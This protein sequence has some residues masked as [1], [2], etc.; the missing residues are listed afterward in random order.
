MRRS[1]LSPNSEK[2]VQSALRARAWSSS[3]LNSCINDALAEPVAASF[4]QL[5]QSSQREPCCSPIAARRLPLEDCIVRL[6][7]QHS[8]IVKLRKFEPP[9]II[10]VKTK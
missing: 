7:T 9:R 3:Y 1:N 2:L 4:H 6:T 10:T 5:V 8:V